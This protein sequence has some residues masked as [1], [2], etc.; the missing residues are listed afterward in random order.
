MSCPPT[1]TRLSA[2]SR[3][4]R[5]GR[6]VS[7]NT[8]HERRGMLRVTGSVIAAKIVWSVASRAGNNGSD[9]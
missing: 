7:Q 2:V 4:Y 1:S 3:T 8:A 9:S 5:Y 6:A